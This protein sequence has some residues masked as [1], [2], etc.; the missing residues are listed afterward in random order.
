MGAAWGAIFLMSVWAR[1]NVHHFVQFAAPIAMTVPVAVA[2]TIDFTSSKSLRTWLNP[3]AAVLGV[4]WIT[5][6]G[7]W[8]GKPVTDLA[9]AEQ[10]QLLGWMLQGVERNVDQGDQLLDCTGLGVEA[11]LLPRRLNEGHPNFQP[12]VLTERCQNWIE[13]P[14]DIS[15]NVWLLTRQEPGFSSPPQDRWRNVEAWEDGPRRTWMWLLVDM[16]SGQP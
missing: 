1:L 3:L 10:H 8:A 11:A 2:R 7:P 6:Q 5:T 16:G 9:T 12:S 15:G 4:F 13:S 14:P